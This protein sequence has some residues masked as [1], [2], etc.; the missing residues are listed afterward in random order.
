MNQT[1]ERKPVD[2]YGGLQAFEK[3]YGVPNPF[4]EGEDINT[5]YI[6]EGNPYRFYDDG[7]LG[8]EARGF[9]VAWNG[10]P[11]PTINFPETPSLVTRLKAI[12]FRKEREKQQRVEAVREGYSQGLLARV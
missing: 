5:F 12:L 6:R 2:W 4:Q 1:S 9:M 3:T 10:E 8:G 11:D 7:G